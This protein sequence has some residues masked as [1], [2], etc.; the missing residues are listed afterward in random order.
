MKHVVLLGDSIFDNEIYVPGKLS[1]IKQ[2]GN[3]L[4]EAWDVSLLAVDGAITTDVSE[5]LKQVPEMTTHFILSCGGNDALCNIGVL[6]EPVNSVAEAM[7]RFSEIR[8]E[9]KKS[10]SSMLKNVMDFNIP[11]AVCSIYDSIPGIEESALTSLSM[12]NEIILK[13]AFMAN[14]PVIDLRLIFTETSDYSEISP[15]EPS[16][17]G[18]E[19]MTAVIKSVLE[20]H[21]FSSNKSIIY[22]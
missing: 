16:V 1:V 9:F 13:E 20:N 15:I 11:V 7:D 6:N 12:F 22:C 8:N 21:D 3:K 18:G 2:L 14:V 4:N 17:K 5:Q 19:K 10:Y